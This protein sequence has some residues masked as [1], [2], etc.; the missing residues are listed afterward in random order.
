MTITLVYPTNSEL[1]EI[2]ADKIPLLTADRAIFQIMPMR[3]VDTALL[4]WEQKDNYIGLQQ[5][6]GINGEPPRVKPTGAKRYIAQPGYYGEFEVIDELEITMRRPLGQFNGAIPID[7]LVMERQDRLLGR[8]LDR[9]EYI[10]WTLLATGTFS[11]SAPNNTVVHTDTFPVQT[12]TAGVTWA[13]SATAVPIANF[14]AVQ[15]LARGHSVSFG[16][17]AKAYMNQTTF[18]NFIGNTNTSDLFGR[19]QA[20]LATINNLKDLNT[21]LQGDGLPQIV[22]YDL[23]YLDDSNTF[24]KWIPD[25][26][27][28]C[29]GQR[30]AGQTVAE[31]LMTR[32]ANNPNGEPGAYQKIVD[33]PNEVPRTIEVHDGHNGG[34][35]IYFP[36]AVVRMNV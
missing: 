36:S 20:G 23:G 35:A 21:L 7:D 6:R 30:P 24:Q 33:D 12:F 13:T 10:G 2:A 9:I 11:V 28:I 27:V 5:V 34:P 32:N 16:P 26:V 31:Y 14:R 29:V 17:N 8:R 22:I 25:N 18:N 15:I 4:M 19:R 1:I 3:D